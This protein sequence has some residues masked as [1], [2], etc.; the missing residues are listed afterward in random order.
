MIGIHR[1]PLHAVAQPSSWLG[2]TWLTNPSVLSPGSAWVPASWFSMVLMLTWHPLFHIACI[3]PAPLNASCWVCVSSGHWYFS[4]FQVCGLSRIFLGP[5]YWLQ[6]FTGTHHFPGSSFR[7]GYPRLTLNSPSS[8]SPLKIRISQRFIY[9]KSSLCLWYVGELRK[10]V[11]QCE[12]VAKFICLS[13]LC[14]WSILE[15]GIQGTQ[16]N[17]AT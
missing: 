6:F 10:R 3:L 17:A 15:G 12:V 14:C 11:K 8:L 16:R 7:S 13:D 1:D 5:R 9:A 4:M 2:L